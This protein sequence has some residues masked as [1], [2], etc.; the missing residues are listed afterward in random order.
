MG[1]TYDM[2]GSGK[3]KT[4]IIHII[5]RLSSTSAD[6]SFVLSS[7]VSARAKRGNPYEDMTCTT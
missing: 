5:P 2:K 7:R 6:S 3:E 4:V 1:S